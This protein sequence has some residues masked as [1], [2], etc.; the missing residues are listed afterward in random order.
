MLVQFPDVTGLMDKVGVKLEE[1]KS[2]P[3]KAEPSPFNPTTDE[4]RAMIRAM[5]L[6][7][8][9]WFVGIV[10]ERRPLTATE[11]LALAD[12]S[13]FTGRQALP[14]KLVDELGGEDEAHRLAGRP[15]ASTADLEVVEWKRARTTAS[16][17][18]SRALGGGASAMR[19][20]CPA[21]ERATCCE[22]LGADRIFLDG[23]CRSGN[24]ELVGWRD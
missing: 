14:N 9:D 18:C 6:D 11:V 3:L 23:L 24:L 2:S 5:I 12:G 19:S 21:A 16:S 4:E 15:R 8:Y 7:S 1:V 22:E 17:S 13:V 20:A 10:D